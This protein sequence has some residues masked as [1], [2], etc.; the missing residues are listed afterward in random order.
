MLFNCFNRWH[1][2]LFLVAFNLLQI[3]NFLLMAIRNNNAV[4]MLYKENS[5]PPSSFLPPLPCIDRLL[6]GFS[7]VEDFCEI[8]EFS[9]PSGNF[10]LFSWLLT[11]PLFSFHDVLI[12]VYLFFVF[13]FSSNALFWTS[14]SKIL[15]NLIL[16]LHY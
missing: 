1:T 10:L 16:T 12:L 8:E 7:I 14:N 6:I 15:I 4:S 13:F 9:F 11:P 3:D 2:L 5:L